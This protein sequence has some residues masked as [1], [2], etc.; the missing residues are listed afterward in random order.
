M[1]GADSGKTAASS[2]GD[3]AC[4]ESVSSSIFGKLM[5]AVRSFSNASGSTS[6]RDWA[7]PS[8]PARFRAWRTSPRFCSASRMVSRVGFSSWPTIWPSNRNSTRSAY[9]AASG[10][11]VTMMTDCSQSRAAARRNERT[12]ADEAESRFPVGSS[13][14]TTSGAVN[15]ARAQATFCCCPPLSSEGK[16]PS[17]DSISSSLTSAFSRRR[18]GDWRRTIADNSIFSAT[19]NVGTKLNDWKINPILSRRNRVNSVAFS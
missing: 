4:S 2:A 13:A 3:S 10:S 1:S 5:T 18:S 16:A 6:R 15:N 17:R 9:F 12:C 14:K 11:C 19:F 8:C 7:A